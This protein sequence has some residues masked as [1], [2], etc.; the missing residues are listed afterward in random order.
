[1]SIKA[2]N[3]INN[4]R[5][6]IERSKT[7]LFHTF[8]GNFNFLPQ[9]SLHFIRKKHYFLVNVVKYLIS[10]NF[11]MLSE[12]T[13]LMISVLSQSLLPRLNSSIIHVFHLSLCGQTSNNS[14]AC[15]QEAKS[16]CTRVLVT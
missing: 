4:T 9:V 5:K 8:Y 1:V 15:W 16:V 14:R 6:N 10:L 2:E 13:Y 12:R 3:K 7:Y 11:S